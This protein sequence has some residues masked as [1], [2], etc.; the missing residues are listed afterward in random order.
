MVASNPI[1][2]ASGSEPEVPS[3]SRLVVMR[4]VLPVGGAPRHVEYRID[5][6]FVERLRQL[7]SLVPMITS[8]SR[9]RDL[10][11]DK[12]RVR[13]PSAIW[14][15]VDAEIHVTGSC[16]VVS[17]EGIFHCGGKDTDNGHKL[18]SCTFPISRL[19]DLHGQRPA[20]ETLYIQTGFF[21]NDE[22]A[23]T[24]AG[25]WLAS[26]HAVE[27]GVAVPESA[28]DFD[29]LHGVPSRPELALARAAA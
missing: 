2:R 4:L 27:E 5:D 19:I 12:V 29:T 14:R 8:L 3:S 6:G 23:E 15:R 17:N 10:V 13:L 26:M 16:L 25:R 24:D 9:Q 28:S 22:P 1:D 18:L 11:I 20:G 21:I 7:R